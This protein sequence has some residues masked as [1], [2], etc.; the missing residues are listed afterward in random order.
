M[1]SPDV[2]DADSEELVEPLVGV[3]AY[4]STPIGHPVLAAFGHHRA[5]VHVPAP[6]RPGTTAVLSVT[7]DRPA[8]AGD[9]VELP[10]PPRVVVNDVHDARPNPETEARL[11]RLFAAGM[12]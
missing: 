9:R 6:G 4:N 10:R 11:R 2:W 3:V 1:S 12:P 5:V 7:L 8:R